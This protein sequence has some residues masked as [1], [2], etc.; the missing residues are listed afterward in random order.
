[1][2]GRVRETEECGDNE[3]DNQPLDRWLDLHNGLMDKELDE[4]EEGIQPVH[5]MLTKVRVAVISSR[6]MELMLTFGSPSCTSL[7][8][9]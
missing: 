1:M 7:H 9:L 3:V 8:M 4:I 2:H 5:T 6:A